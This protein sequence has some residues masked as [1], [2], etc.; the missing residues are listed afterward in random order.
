MFLI[1]MTKRLVFKRISFVAQNELAMQFIAR[2]NIL[3][4]WNEKENKIRK[5]KSN[6]LYFKFTRE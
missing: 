2:K 1:K 4:Y 5:T 3:K 6:K